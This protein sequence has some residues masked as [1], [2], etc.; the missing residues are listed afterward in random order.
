MAKGLEV[1]GAKPHYIVRITSSAAGWRVEMYN[2]FNA[3]VEQVARQFDIST[4]PLA[5]I[6]V[7]VMPDKGILIDA[8]HR[9]RWLS[10][11]IDALSSLRG[12]V[13]TRGRRGRGGALRALVDD[14]H[15]TVQ[16]R[17]WIRGFSVTPPCPRQFRVG[18]CDSSRRCGADS[19]MM[20]VCR[21]PLKVEIC[22]L[23]EEQLLG[24]FPLRA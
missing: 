14:Q 20:C 21:T 5:L 13:T 11:W 7:D 24:G 9:D 10:R 12:S 22:R 4:P 3:G 19:R 18:L 1:A 6:G 16:P 8:G 17:S 15:A 23:H 2:A